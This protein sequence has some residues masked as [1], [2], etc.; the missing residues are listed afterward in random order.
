MIAFGIDN[1]GSGLFL[2]LTLVFVT[3]VVGLSVAQTGVTVTVGTLAGVAVLSV[4]GSLVERVGARA[5][6]VA[7]HL[8]RAAGAGLYL[9]ADGIVSVGLAAVLVAAGQQLFHGALFML[10]SDVAGDGPKDHVFT[11]VAMVRG[12]SFAL[13][14]LVVGALLNTAGPVGYRW[15]VIVD[16]ASF[17]IAAAVL[18]LGLRVTP[19]RQ[20]RT[21][22]R[23][24]GPAPGTGVWRDRPFL[25]L[26]AITMLFALALDFFLVGMPVYILDILASL[27]W[28][29]GALLAVLTIVG[30]TTGTLVLRWTGHWS[31]ITAMQVAASVAAGWLPPQGGPATCSAAPSCS[32][33]PNSSRPV[34]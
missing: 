24:A 8:L 11:V 34:G 1:F 7:A 23:P 32:R 5:V 30:S 16:V 33:R 3:Q 17:V 6:V 15:G 29:P 21:A 10:I 26:I 31:R 22:G 18:V 13:G 25:T 2:P 4:A 27:S 12:A 9:L 14:A 19:D 28:L 20:P